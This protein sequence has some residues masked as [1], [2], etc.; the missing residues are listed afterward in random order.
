MKKFKQLLSLLLAMLMMVTLLTACG[1]TSTDDD[2]DTD[3]IVVSDDDSDSESE[4]ADEEEETITLNVAYMPN[5]GSLWSVLATMDLGYFE[6]EGLEINLIEFADGPTIIA[7][8]EGGS[9]D[10][11]Y[12]GQGAHKLCIQGNAT[13]ICMSHVDNG[14]AVIGGANVQ[15]LE[16]LAGKTV[17]YSSGTSSETILLSALESVGL[18]MDDI[19]A[20]DMDATA[21]VTAMI[22]GS[23]DACAV[24]SPASLTILEEDENATLLCDNSTFSDTTIA[25]ASWIATPS[26]LEENR[27]ICVR[28]IRALL[29]GMTYAADEANYEYVSELVATQCA[30]D[31]DT[32]YEQ[33]GDGEWYTADMIAEAIEDGSMEA[34][35]Q[36]QQEN[37]LS[38]GSIEES[39]VCDVSTYVD[40]DLMT[41]A[42]GE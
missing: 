17:A 20:M 25:L 41:E 8:M 27:D 23:V 1:D 11:G 36:L 22:S 37:F 30:T 14:D 24:W 9:I 31:Y 19:T 3:E 2:S 34:F 4:N 26:Y 39:D 5:Y 12:I 40:F 18:T 32:A 38:A 6:E 29:K 16:D 13:I 33:R 28:F 21:M 10:I 15:T 42:L 35:Y 7:A